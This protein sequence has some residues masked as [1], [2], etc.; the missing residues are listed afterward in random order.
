MTGRWA[1]LLIAAAMA[2]V[3][4][5]ARAEDWPTRP[6]HVI[7]GAG[8]GG[9]TDIVTRIIGQPL[10]E[11]LG[12]PVVVEN[13]QGPANLLAAG[14]LVKAAKDGYT[15]Y[16]INNSHGIVGALYKNLPFDPVN[17][18]A[19][20][21]FTGVAGL[22]LVTRKDFP[23]GNVK[24]LIAAAKAQPGRLNFASVGNGTTQH[25]SG[26]LFRQLAGIDVKHIPYRSSPAAITGLLAGEVDFTFELVQAV[27]G[28]IRAGE[29]KPLAVTS[30]VHDPALPDLPTVAESG[31]PS[32]QV[33]SWYGLTFPAGTPEPI[34]AKMNQALHQVLARED[35]R[36]QLV[37][38]G[39]TAKTSTPEELRQHVVNEIAKWNEVREKAGIEKRE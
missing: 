12:Q 31:L 24:E 38:V 20:V 5:G 37:K 21:G 25:F 1:A 3:P 36:A 16:M 39:A 8:P 19:F 15:A 35:I 17:D 34:I 23:A 10:S 30:P 11:L 7:V 22:A 29:L 4:A 26:E 2:L 33:M 18:F 6:I 13:K 14:A 28:Q 27:L 32:F 9:G